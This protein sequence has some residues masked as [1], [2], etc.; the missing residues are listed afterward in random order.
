LVLSIIL[1]VITGAYRPSLRNGFVN[2][3]DDVHLYENIH[4]KNLSLENLVGMFTSTINKTYIPLTTLS[5]AVEHAVFKDNPF[6]YHLN[7]LIFH[8]LTVMLIYW[9]AVEMGLSFIGA[10]ITALL[11]GIHP[12][13]VESVAW[14]T[15][16]K[17]V[18]YAFLYMLSL[19]FYVRYVKNSSIFYF[20]AACALGV[21]SML[22]KPMALSLP[23]IFLIVDWFVRRPLNR[24][25]AYLEKIPI[26]LVIAALGLMTY[27]P[28]ARGFES[29]AGEGILIWLWTFSFYLKQFL[30]PMYLVPIHRLPLP[31]SLN[32]E[33][34][35][36]AGIF[37]LVILLLRRFRKSRWF[38]FSM[39]FY[40]GSIFF[41]LR[42]DNAADVNI[43]ADRFMYLPSLGFC[44]LFGFLCERLLSHQ[45]AGKMWMRRLLLVS[46]VLLGFAF[47]M[48]TFQQTRIW[49]DSV[50]LWYYQLTINPREY[51]ALNN[52]ATVLRDELPFQR[53]EQYYRHLNQLRKRGA[54]LDDV[55]S[56]AMTNLLKVKYISAL[57]HRAMD[58]KP[59]Y[60]DAYYNMGN[61]FFDLQEWE[62][63]VPY[64]AQV[65]AMDADHKD[66]K[67]NLAKVYLTEAEFE[68]AQTLFEE[69]VAQDPMDEEFYSNIILAIQ[70][71]LTWRGPD[72]KIENIRQGFLERYVELARRHPNSA[73]SFFNLGNLYSQTGDFQRAA[74]SFQTALKQDSRNTQILYNLANTYDELGDDQRAVETYRQV[75]QLDPGF[76][77]AHLNLGVAYTRLGQIA[78]ARESFEKAIV[79][80][81]KDANAYYN[82]GYIQ[83]MSAQFPAALNS[84]QEAIKLDPAHTEAYYNM[85][86]VLVVLKDMNAARASYESAVSLNPKHL[87][88][89]VNLSILSYRQKD[90]A[91][92]IK[93]CDEARILGYDAPKEYL[94]ALSEYR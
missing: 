90:M 20:T 34:A 32:T 56:S 27:L 1:F 19:C 42:F 59:D 68:K 64:Y 44:L 28:H 77:K 12:M 50:T 60:I 30:F 37:L 25:G 73:G 75:I 74:E 87:D 17:D 48:R 6:V 62:K 24:S 41:L 82:L 94:D 16:R 85:G 93:Y 58:I 7:N 43:V 83:E 15:E 14:I 55:D 84:Y 69:I 88:A 8:I 36:A 81:S 3:D 86:N 45:D 76:E 70:D 18:L 10:G 39:L 4:V 57:Y 67:L 66:A 46:L 22:A 65:L 91:A 35:L 47:S 71:V 21:L 51:I 53:A 38:V 40:V 29:S 23:L 2:W 9:F 80:N 54:N 78:E 61:L 63:A 89:L 26:L 52:L 72:L 79:L 92:A 31:V 33:Y 13:H 5:F 49:R 11:F